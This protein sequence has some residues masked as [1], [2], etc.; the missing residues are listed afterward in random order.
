[1]LTLKRVLY[2]I[3]AFAIVLVGGSF[4]LPSQAK[5]SRSIDIAAPPEQVFAIVGDLRR[6][7]DFWPKA[8]MEG[9]ISYAFEGTESGL[10]QRLA[11]QSDNP[12]VGSG[13]T[14]IVAYSP[15]GEVGFRTIA[16]RERWLSG[17]VL[18]PTTAGTNVTWTFATDLIGVP[19]RWF[20]LLYEGRIGPEYEQGLEKLK[21]VAEK[22]A[23][24]Q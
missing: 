11:W 20:G 2:W 6:F 10:G 22:P 13:A 4:L 9:K 7:N 19:A 12:E 24:P 17:F 14:T 5:V 8:E 23:S 1:M 3:S 21:A 16:G 18:V 15:P